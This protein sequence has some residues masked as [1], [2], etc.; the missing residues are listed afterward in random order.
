MAIA[1]APMCRAQLVNPTYTGFDLQLQQLQE[2][3]GTLRQELHVE[4]PRTEPEIGRH[5]KRSFNAEP[6]PF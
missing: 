5:L 1:G 4:K 6:A 2:A 3:A